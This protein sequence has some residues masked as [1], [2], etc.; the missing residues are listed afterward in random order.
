MQE[1]GEGVEEDPSLLVV[2]S[3]LSKRSSVSLRSCNNFLFQNKKKRK[4]P[5]Y[6]VRT[7]VQVMKCSAGSV[8]ISPTD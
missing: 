7:V 4:C 2:H 6:T 8:L 5:L 3:F 1:V